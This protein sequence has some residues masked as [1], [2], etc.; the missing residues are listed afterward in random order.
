MT[1]WFQANLLTINVNKN[2]C[3]LFN[4]SNKS[5]S[6]KFELELNNIKLQSSEH[7]KILGLWIDQT[8]S[9]RIHTSNLLMK[10][11]QNIHLLKIGNKFL[12]KSSKKL[13]YYAHIYSH[14]CYGLV[15]WGNMLDNTTKKKI[16]KSMDTCFNLITHLKPSKENYKKERMLRLDDLLHLEISKLGYK[17]E[18]N[19]LP[20]NLHK[21]MISDSNQKSLTKTHQYETRTKEIPVSHLPKAKII[22][23]A[24]SFNQSK[25][26]RKYL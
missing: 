16:Q 17:L 4:H 23:T 24:F 6:Y 21:M 18:H 7:T 11:K 15:I 2:E 20:E 8:L 13:V 9:W 25:N 10:I 26:I 5:S 19:L 14:I 12:T 3:I 1:D 22:M